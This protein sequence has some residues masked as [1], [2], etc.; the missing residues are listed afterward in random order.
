MMSPAEY[1]SALAQ[2][3]PPITEEQVE[4]TAR[5]L[6]TVELEQVAA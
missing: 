4:A 6:A 2:L 1:G 5:I 3:L